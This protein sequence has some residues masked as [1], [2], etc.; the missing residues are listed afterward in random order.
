MAKRRHMGRRNVKL[1]S[2]I[3]DCEPGRVN[4]EQPTAITC[5]VLKCNEI[6]CLLQDVYR[7]LRVGE[8]QK[9]SG[10]LWGD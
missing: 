3:K 8:V 10:L 6:I 2:V 1:D 7:S 5:R 9:P 4:G